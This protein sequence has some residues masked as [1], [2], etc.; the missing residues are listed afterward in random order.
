MLV[1]T[2]EGLGVSKGM[3]LHGCH[4]NAFGFPLF[5]IGEAI[6]SLKEPL[7]DIADTGEEISMIL[8]LVSSRRGVPES[9]SFCH[10]RDPEMGKGLFLR[11]SQ[12]GDRARS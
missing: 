3:Y 12:G 8:M 1:S 2:R 5:S 10:M 9:F 11:A 7:A 4:F 6:Q